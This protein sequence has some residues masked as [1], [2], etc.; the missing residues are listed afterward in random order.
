MVYIH[1]YVLVIGKTLIFAYF[2]FSQ[3]KENQ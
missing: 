3:A 1:T 2:G